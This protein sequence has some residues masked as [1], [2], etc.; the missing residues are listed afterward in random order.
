M[1]T[2]KRL[3]KLI[4]SL[5]V[6]IVCTIVSGLLMVLGFDKTVDRFIKYC[7]SKSKGA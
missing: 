1:K 7:E 6:V 4:V 3:F 5:P 2:I